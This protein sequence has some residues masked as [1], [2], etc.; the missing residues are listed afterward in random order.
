MLKNGLFVLMLA[1]AVFAAG[2]VNDAKK[3]AEVKSGRLQ[4][5]KASWWGFDKTNSTKCL[6]EAINSG[7]KKLTVDNTGSPWIIDPIT[8]VDNQEII[9]AD[10]VQVLARVDGFKG[11]EDSLFTADRKQ[12]ITLRGDGRV[13]LKM[14]KKDY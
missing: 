10:G 9:F 12:N 2:C 3:I 1:G 8:L 6:Q 5:A 7:V 11:K 13:V 4:E 14:N